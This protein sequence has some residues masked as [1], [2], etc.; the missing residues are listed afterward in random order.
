MVIALWCTPDM[1]DSKSEVEQCRKELLTC[2]LKTELQPD[3]HKE[4][5]K[6]FIKP[7]KGAK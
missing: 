4:L 2:A 6:C 5:I 7:E 1:F 3:K